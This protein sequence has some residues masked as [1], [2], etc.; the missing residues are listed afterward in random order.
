MD[1]IESDDGDAELDYDEEGPDVLIPGFVNGQTIPLW[2][3][4]IHGPLPIWPKTVSVKQVH[5]SRKKAVHI[6][7]RGTAPGIYFDW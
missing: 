3:L 6:V 7:F 1:D 2:S 4:R 5:G